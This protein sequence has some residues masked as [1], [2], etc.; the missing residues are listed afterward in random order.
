MYTSSII[1]LYYLIN[2]QKYY[3]APFLGIEG[4]HDLSLVYLYSC[5]I[6]INKYLS[7]FLHKY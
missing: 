4:C 2:I 1:I 6:L 7:L 5:I 3:Y